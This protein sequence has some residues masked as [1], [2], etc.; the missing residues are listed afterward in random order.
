[1]IDPWMLLGTALSMLMLLAGTAL[2]V[3]LTVIGLRDLRDHD[4]AGIDATHP[5]LAPDGPIVKRGDLL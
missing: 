5:L 2:S 4:L 1:M 3:A